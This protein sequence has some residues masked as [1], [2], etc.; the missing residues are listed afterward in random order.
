MVMVVLIST[1]GAL[2]LSVRANHDAA[3]KVIGRRAYGRSDPEW[4]LARRSERFIRWLRDR[5]ADSG[6]SEGEQQ[7]VGRKSSLGG[8][9]RDRERPFR[10]C[11][12]G[13]AY[14][15]SLD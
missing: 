12:G 5:D 6:L 14:L 10:S 1:D 8:P 2:D 15:N 3:V 4:R 13:P 11:P 9:R 7:R